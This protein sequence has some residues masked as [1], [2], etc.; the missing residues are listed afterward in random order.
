MKIMVI[1]IGNNV[2]VKKSLDTTGEGISELEE[3]PREI[4]HNAAQRQLKN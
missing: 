4:I 3:R 2:Q 1:R